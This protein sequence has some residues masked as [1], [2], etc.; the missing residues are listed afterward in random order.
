M[1]EALIRTAAV[2]AAIAIAAGPAL[3]EAAKSWL[4]SAKS[5]L[6][7]PATPG[8]KEG[9]NDAHVVV[10]I[11]RRLQE[12]GNAEGSALCHKLLEILLRPEASK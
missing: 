6:P 1:S 9:M 4:K 10:E 2:L 11:A 7:S 12:A 3:V 8:G 5:R